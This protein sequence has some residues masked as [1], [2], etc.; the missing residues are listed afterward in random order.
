MFGTRIST[1]AFPM[2]VLHLDNSPLIAGLVAFAAIAPSMLLY[3]PAGALVSRWNPWRVM[4]VSEWLR[5][6]AIISVV[7]LLAI[8]GRHTSIWFV[9]FAMVAEEIFEIF[10]TLADRRYLSRMIGR[11][12]IAS[13]QAYVEVRSHAAVLAGRPL[14]PLLFVIQPFLPFLADGAS[15]LFSIGSLLLVRRP[16]Q[17]VREARRIPSGQL[18][19]DVHSGFSLLNK[20]RRAFA[21][22][23]L[24]AAGS[25]VAQ[26]LILIFLSAAHSREVPIPAIGFVLAASGVGGAAGSVAYRFVPERI[27]ECWLPVQ[28]TTWG[29]ALA[30]LAMPG[31]FSA[32]RGAI[33]MLTIGLTGAIGNIRFGSYLVTHV[34][35]DM[36]AT[37]TGISQMLLIG[38]YALGPVVGG[39]TV[40]HAGVKGAI[41]ILLVFVVLLAF[42]SILIPKAE[43]EA[44]GMRGRTLQQLL[45]VPIEPPVDLPAIPSETPA[46]RDDKER[47][48]GGLKGKVF[49]GKPAILIGKHVVDYS[50]PLPQDSDLEFC[51]AGIGFLGIRNAAC[52]IVAHLQEESGGFRRERE[53]LILQA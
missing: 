15:F 23:L 44:A 13:R 22:V 27:K 8:F 19:K 29:L 46:I 31:G 34:A 7:V 35:D 42:L 48:S 18:R 12:N 3:I 6:L 50:R 49:A 28:M 4:L 37:V 10:F 5:G 21:T 14:G 45:S 17:P 24:M 52:T 11:D 39:A 43:E 26:A 51:R 1:V 36:I 30:L 33:V 20:D 40:Q 47:S 41:E 53:A 25:T 9:M 16:D 32:S 2:L 38:A